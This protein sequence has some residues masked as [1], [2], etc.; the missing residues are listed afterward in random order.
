MVNFSNENSI[1]F[2]EVVQFT[3]HPSPLTVKLSTLIVN[4]SHRAS[5]RDEVCDKFCGFIPSACAPCIFT[6]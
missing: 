1:I 5:R 4:S 6:Y 2:I 3:P